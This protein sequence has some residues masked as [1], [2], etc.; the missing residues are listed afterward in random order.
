MVEGYAIEEALGFCTE[1]LQDFI[2]TKHRV[3][4][5]KK[6]FACMMKFLKAMGIHE[7]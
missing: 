5:D 7:Y 2:A 6:T 3:W 4:D 1:Y